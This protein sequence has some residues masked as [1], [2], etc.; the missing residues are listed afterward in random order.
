MVM[1]EDGRKHLEFTQQVIARMGNNSFSLK[2]WSIT[3]LAA[4]FALAADKANT[5]TVWVAI[6]PVL[7]FWILDAYFFAQERV[8][9]A[10]YD[11]LRKLSDD[12]WNNLGENRY[13][14]NPADFDLKPES[15]TTVMVR[16]TA[17]VLYG[18]LMASVIA[19]GAILRYLH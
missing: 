16:P 14:L 6:I 15:L 3:L 7:V 8:Y 10:L 9:R 1:T 2:G 18:T 5:T 17:L 11:K 12:E 13:S 19:F 4:I